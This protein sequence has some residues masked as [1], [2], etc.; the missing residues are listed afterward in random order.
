MNAAPNHERQAGHTHLIDLALALSRPVR[1]GWL[2]PTVID[3]VLI[4]AADR[5]GIA[6]DRLAD[7]AAFLGRIAR[8][9]A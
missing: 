3:V 2:H 5:A 8:G 6:G 9:D 7:A 4:L 1:F